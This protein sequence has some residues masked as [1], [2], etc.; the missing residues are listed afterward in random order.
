MTVATKI[1]EVRQQVKDW[2]K[3]KNRK[4]MTITQEA[5][6]QHLVGR[7][8]I[9]QDVAQAAL[10][11]TSDEAGFI[12]GSNLVIDGGMTVKMIYAD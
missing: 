6:A 3:K 5:H 2:K 7:V 8:G 9:P 4:F 1:S 10:F 12:T 11:L